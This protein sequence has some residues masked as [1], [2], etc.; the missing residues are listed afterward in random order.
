MKLSEKLVWGVCIVMATYS[1]FYSSDLAIKD[2]MDFLSLFWVL[3]FAII[4]WGLIGWCTLWVW[5]TGIPKL[6]SMVVER[7]LT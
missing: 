5:G 4:E 1:F 3:V 6:K 7:C 2:G